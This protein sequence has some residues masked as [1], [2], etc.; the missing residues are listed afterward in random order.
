[1]DTRLHQHCDALVKQLDLPSPWHIMTFI[2]SL[3]EA[4]GRPLH[5]LPVDTA[6]GMHGLW[7]ATSQADYIAYEQRTTRPHQHQIILHEVAHMLWAHPSRS[8]NELDTVIRSR[9]PYAA[10]QE[11]EAEATATLIMQHANSV[12]Q[13][14]TVAVAAPAMSDEVR[15]VLE[16]FSPG[17]TAPNAANPGRRRLAGGRHSVVSAPGQAPAHGW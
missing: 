11:R 3:A 6:G 13:A 10:D 12:Q 4:N 7:V 1:M 8:L 15:R 2:G 14:G 5:L 17:R 9:V 16:T